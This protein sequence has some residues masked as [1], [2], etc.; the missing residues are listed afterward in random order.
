MYSACC[1]FLEPLGFTVSASFT[2]PVQVVVRVHSYSA[3][4]V[5]P[6]LMPA[7]CTQ[8]R[9]MA[10]AHEALRTA[11]AAADTAATNKEATTEA[12]EAARAAA[13]EA[14]AA[15]AAGGDT[16]AEDGTV[17]GEKEEAEDEDDE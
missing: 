2:A 17:D 1:A 4:P 11:K 3:I 7:C 6:L 5:T 9:R 12:L 10:R 14:A 16:A 8:M 13:A 15:A